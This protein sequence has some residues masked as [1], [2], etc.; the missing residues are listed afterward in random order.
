V[1]CL[2]ELTLGER[3]RQKHGH[4][5]QRTLLSGCVLAAYFATIM[6]AASPSWRV[7]LY[8]GAV[9]PRFVTI[10]FDPT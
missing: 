4:Y 5:C 10:K 6:V 7:A 1:A 2:A 9:E 3:Y 8:G